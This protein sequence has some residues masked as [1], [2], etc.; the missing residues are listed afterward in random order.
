MDALPMTPY[1]LAVIPPVANKALKSHSFDIKT[2]VAVFIYGAALTIITGWRYDVA[3]ALAW[4]IAL[5]S[6][7]I[8]GA[9]L[10]DTIGKVV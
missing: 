4:T 7:L 5:T 9:E 6:I 2:I 3:S 8:N 1:L 10:F